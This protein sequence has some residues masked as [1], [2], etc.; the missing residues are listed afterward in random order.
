MDISDI[1][2]AIQI[3]KIRITDHADEEAQ[4][5]QF[6]FEDIYY[7]VCHGEIIEDYPVDRDHIQ[8]A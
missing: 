8:V 7:S 5:D 2:K 3:S 1:I 6:S 4:A